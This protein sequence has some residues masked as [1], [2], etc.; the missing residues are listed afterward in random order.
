[1]KKY[2]LI[3]ITLAL[4]VASCAS[5]RDL[6]SIQE[7]DVSFSSMKFD[8]ISFDGITMLFDFEVDN[9]NQANIKAT[10][11]NYEFLL[12][13]NTFLTGT[14]EQGIEIKSKS[15][16]NVTVPV[17]FNFDQVWNSVRSIAQNDSI[18]YNLS[19]EVEF[20]LPILGSRKV[21]VTASGFF[22][23]IK[24]PTF[25][26]S[27]FNRGRLSL[28]GAELELKVII[29]NPN[30]FAI[31]VD[32][33][34]YNLIVNGA[35]WAEST[36]SQRVELGSDTEREVTIPLQLNFAQLGSATYQLLTGGSSFNYE[37][38]GQTNAGADI[39]GFREN[40]QIPF[41]FSGVFR[42]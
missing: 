12:N 1:M 28:S 11:Y 34:D 36:I 2:F 9:P 15:K 41:N 14:Q 27:D 39:P 18:E 37:V 38:T 35:K 31:W 17:T 13:G 25:E 33:V 19:T 10:S 24:T 7:P 29:K 40:T 32:G 30:S 21:P 20:D 42:F 8:N 4:F 6:A 16:N 3:L 22:P 23:L 5:I 26:F